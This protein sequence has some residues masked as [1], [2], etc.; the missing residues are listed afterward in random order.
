MDGTDASLTIDISGDSKKLRVEV[1]RHGWSGTLVV[2]DERGAELSAE[3][4]YSPYQRGGLVEA[5]LPKGCRR[6]RLGMRPSEGAQG[7][8]AWI[9]GVGTA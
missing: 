5:S 1:W 6:V 2:F 4:L 7:V 3:N 9:M 8:Q